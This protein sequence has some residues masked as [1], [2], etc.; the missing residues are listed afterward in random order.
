MDKPILIIFAGLIGTG[1]STLSKTLSKKL[2]IPI[3]SSDIVRKELSG[4]SPTEH[5]YEDFEKGI[6]SKEFTDK[7]YKEIFKKAEEFLM[8]GSSVIIDASFKKKSQR[9]MILDLAVEMGIRYFIIETIC[10]DEE[11]KKR[12]N[13]RLKSKRAT[14]DGRLE[15]YDKQKKD[16]DVIN[17]IDR[18]SHIIID[19]T[20]PIDVCI[21]KILE[22]LIHD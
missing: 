4:I 14:S 11:I 1:K 22:R 8:K 21:E 7:T 16:F 6:Y 15:I 20:K 5:K 3:I 10:K 18:D 19:T 9:K 12:L 17:E 2:D 13:Y